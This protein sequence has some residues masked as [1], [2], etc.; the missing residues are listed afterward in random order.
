MSGDNK[1]TI[2]SVVIIAVVVIIGVTIAAAFSKGQTSGNYLTATT[3][4]VNPTDWLKGNK[5]GKVSVI[6]YGD[7]QCPACA[8]YYPLAEELVK[9]YSGQIQFVFRNFP[10]YQVHPNAGITAQAAG[11]A[12]LQGKFW[13]MYSLLYEK[14]TEWA[15]ADTKTIIDK[16]LNG[17]AQSIGLDVKKFDTDIDSDQV[18]TKIQNDVKSANDSSLDHTPTFFINLKEIPNPQSYDEFK[19]AVDTALQNS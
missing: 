5:D 7:F 1:V 14:Q 11:A 3:E 2:W 9:N 10:L 19:S 17:Y 12:G 13:E 15:S 4:A 8:T 6:E 16:Y 18:K